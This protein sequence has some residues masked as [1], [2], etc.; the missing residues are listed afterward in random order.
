MAIPDT[1]T[2]KNVWIG[3]NIVII[4]PIIEIFWKL[5]LSQTLPNHG[6]KWE[7][8]GCEAITFIPIYVFA[9]E[10]QT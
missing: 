9:T 7:P 5:L 1:I 4:I 2:T 3:E 6:G 8:V 10:L